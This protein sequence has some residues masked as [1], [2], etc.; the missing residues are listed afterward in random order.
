MKKSFWILMFVAAT[1]AHAAD[2]LVD[3]GIAEIETLGRINGQALACSEQSLA[4]RTKE[5]ML[6]HAPRTPRYGSAFEQATQ[7]GF[8]DQVKGK[9]AC[10]PASELAQ[11][12]DLVAVELGK[13]L[14]ASE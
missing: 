9:L 4:A 13:K 2:A 5:L 6:K 11:R 14:P 7:R 3:S 8:M 10:P 1:S 12:I